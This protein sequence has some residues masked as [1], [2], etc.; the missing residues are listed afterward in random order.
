M[1][2]VRLYRKAGVLV[3]YEAAG[4]ALPKAQITSKET[5]DLVCGAVSVLTQTGVNALCE[6][7]ALTP[8]VQVDEASGL[9]RCMLPEHLPQGARKQ[10]TTILET[11][12]VGLQGIA[13]A[14]PRYLALEEANLE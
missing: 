14:Y 12:R 5:L 13:K 2:K 6:L 10:A 11:I 1:T 4:H 7:A 8:E 3:G 9:L